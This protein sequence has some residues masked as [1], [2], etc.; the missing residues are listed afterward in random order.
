MSASRS[1]RYAF[2]FWTACAFQSPPSAA[3][4]LKSGSPP[5]PSLILKMKSL[6]GYSTSKNVR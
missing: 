6:A 5:R 1:T 3:T 4:S 2:T